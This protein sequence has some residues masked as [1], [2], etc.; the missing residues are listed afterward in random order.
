VTKVLATNGSP[1]LATPVYIPFPGAMRNATNRLCPLAEPRLQLREERTRARFRNHVA[2]RQIAL[3]STGA[4]W[5]K[6]NMDTVLRI[7]RELAEDASVLFVGGLL[8]PH[9]FPMKQNA[10]LT[11][12][13]EAL[14]RAARRAGRELITEGRVHQETFDAVSC[15]L[16]AEEELR[17]HYNAP[18]PNW[19]YLRALPSLHPH[20]PHHTEDSQAMG[21]WPARTGR[22]LTGRRPMSIMYALVPATMRHGPLQ[23][24]PRTGPVEISL[25]ANPGFR[26]S[27]RGECMQLRRGLRSHRV[28]SS[29]LPGSANRAR[30]TT[31]PQR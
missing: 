2:I 14:L 7:A 30:L 13:G 22:S 12:D 21:T 18:L 8:R 17:R 10:E 3:V 20:A 29:T 15:P 5:E 16:I 28:N 4:W 27:G 31:F 25:P 9:A 6:E 19:G 11:P 24:R 1:L 26:P 23:A